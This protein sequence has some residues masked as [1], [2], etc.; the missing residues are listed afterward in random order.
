M[1]LLT[2]R[3]FSICRSIK[4]KETKRLISIQKFIRNFRNNLKLLICALLNPRKK[5]LKA[6]EQK[7]L[8]VA[9]RSFFDK[10][11]RKTTEENLMNHDLPENVL[12]M[13]IA[14]N[15]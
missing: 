1:L 15:F 2:M 14:G 13:L 10:R 4:V 7:I 12:T 3:M 6:L 8:R 11:N 5:L 9:R